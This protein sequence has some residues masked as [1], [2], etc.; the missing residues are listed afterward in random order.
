M[1]TRSRTKTRVVQPGGGE[2]GREGGR[3]T[4]IRLQGEKKEK[5]VGKREI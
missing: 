2:E 4:E 3:L 1:D 5:K